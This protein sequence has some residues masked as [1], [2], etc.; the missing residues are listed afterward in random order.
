MWK[1]HRYYSEALD[2]RNLEKSREEQFAQLRSHTG[3]RLVIST[4]IS[5]ASDHRQIE[6]PMVISI[7]NSSRARLNSLTSCSR[8]IHPTMSS[9]CRTKV[10]G[11]TAKKNAFMIV[12]ADFDF[13]N[14]ARRRG[15]PPKVVRLQ[16]CNY[17]TAKVEDLLRRHAIRISELD[18]SSRAT[19]I[20][21]NIG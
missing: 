11:N 13:L 12:T 3:R 2:I 10:A 15:V 19:L 16:N 1:I 18:H 7:P 4:L 20:I 6:P 5:E 9:K 14:L 21:R 17:R 8:M